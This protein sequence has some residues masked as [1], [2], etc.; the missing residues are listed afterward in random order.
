MYLTFDEWKAFATKFLTDR[1]VDVRTSDL[2]DIEI[3]L[4][5]H[6]GYQGISKRFLLLTAR[7]I[8]DD[9]LLENQ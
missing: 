5:H 1:G 2:T 8:R 7:L 9:N 3:A 6:A 4:H